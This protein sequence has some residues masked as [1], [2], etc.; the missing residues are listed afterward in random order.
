MGDSNDENLELCLKKLYELEA[1]IKFRLHNYQFS[2]GGLLR[3]IK[4]SGSDELKHYTLLRIDFKR[5]S[6]RLF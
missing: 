6:M 1:S 3:F 2:D 5:E 4:T